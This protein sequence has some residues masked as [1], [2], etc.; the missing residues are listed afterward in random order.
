MRSI[1]GWGCLA[2]HCRPSG[3]AYVIAL[4]HPDRFAVCPSP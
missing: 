2:T 4:P 1:A 3:A